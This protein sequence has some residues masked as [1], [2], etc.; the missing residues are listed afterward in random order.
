MPS[1]EDILKK[2]K[3]KIEGHMDAESEG[4]VASAESSLFSQDYLDIKKE[5]LSKKRSGY[6]KWCNFFEKAIQFKPSKSLEV[7]LQ[8][9]IETTHLDITPTGATSFAVFTGFLIILLGIFYVL[10]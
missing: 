7:E 9:S 5:I 4:Q 1:E 10:F 2:Y 8:R 3:S 6:E